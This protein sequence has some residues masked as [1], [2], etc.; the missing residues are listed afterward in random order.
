MFLNIEHLGRS[1]TYLLVALQ[2][3]AKSKRPVLV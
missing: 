2:R 1:F 3:R